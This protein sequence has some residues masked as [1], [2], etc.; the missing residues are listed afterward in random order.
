M[1]GCSIMHEEFK[2]FVGIYARR[3]EFF[4]PILPVTNRVLKIDWKCCTFHLLTSEFFELHIMST[5]KADNKKGR[6]TNFVKCFF[7]INSAKKSKSIENE[8]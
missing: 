3:N 1:I 8:R 4:S 2:F 7:K 6:W 5:N